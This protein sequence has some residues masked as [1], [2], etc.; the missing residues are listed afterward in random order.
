M[1]GTCMSDNTERPR[2]ALHVRERTTKRERK[3]GWG[4]ERV[5]VYMSTQPGREGCENKDLCSGY[6]ATSQG[7]RLV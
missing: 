4:G 3:R 5:R 7:A 1:S 6:G 2:A